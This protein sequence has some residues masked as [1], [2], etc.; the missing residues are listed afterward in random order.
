MICSGALL[1]EITGDKA[2]LDDAKITAEG[3]YN[4]FGC[5]EDDGTYKFRSDH[6]WFNSWLLRGYE[7]LIKADPETDGKYLM[8]FE[9]AIDTCIK[10]PRP[11]GYYYKIWRKRD[12]EKR[13]SLIDQTGTLKCFAILLK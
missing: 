6:P 13:V 1:F 10:N 12:E 4:H 2:Y 8:S 11:D 5:M 3:S 9:S 7:E